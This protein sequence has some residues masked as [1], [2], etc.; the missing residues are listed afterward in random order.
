MIDL[1]LF[2]LVIFSIVIAYR[3]PSISIDESF[4]LTEESKEL[5][6]DKLVDRLVQDFS[7]FYHTDIGKASVKKALTSLAKQSAREVILTDS[8]YKDRMLHKIALSII[9]NKING[10]EFLDEIIKR[11]KNKQLN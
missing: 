6:V 3:K 11:I 2:I 9:D 4:E 8:D 10:E 1:I 5:I 7:N